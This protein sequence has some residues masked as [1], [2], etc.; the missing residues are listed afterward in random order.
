MPK[1]L[2]KQLLATPAGCVKSYIGNSIIVIVILVQD[3]NRQNEKICSFFEKYAG[4]C[5]CIPI[6]KRTSKTR[7]A[8]V[9]I[10]NVFPLPQ[11]VKNHL[12]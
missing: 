3:I 11:A 12:K 6:Q 5:L 4:Q 2:L 10:R 7:H 8:F 9:G 1:I